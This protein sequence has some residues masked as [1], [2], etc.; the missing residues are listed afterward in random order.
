MR[1][2]EAIKQEH[3]KSEHQKAMLNILVTSNCID[4]D[5]AKIL[6]PFEIS[7]QQYNVLRILKGQGDKAISVSNIMSRMI[8]KMS[9]V[10]RLLEKLRKKEL[11]ERVV[12]ASDRRQVD[13][14][15]TQEGL[16]LLVKIEK[17]MVSFDDGLSKITTKE[18][19]RLNKILEKIRS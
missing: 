6:K 18:A 10:S 16:E 12:C 13:V 15:I 4:A 3:F 1:L 17:V 11:V 7:S 19:E 5:F 9:N 2:E 14:R 8:D